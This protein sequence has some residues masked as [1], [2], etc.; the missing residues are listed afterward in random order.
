M[1]NQDVVLGKNSVE[2]VGIVKE[3]KL[4]EITYTK[5]GQEFEAISGSLV[6]ACGEFKTVE[7]RLMVNKL[8]KKGTVNKTYEKLQGFI[9]GDYLTMVD[10][11]E[12]ATRVKIRGNGD[13]TPKLEENRFAN[14]ERTEVI[15]APSVSL[16][17]GNITIDNTIPEEDFKAMVDVDVYIGSIEEEI[18]NNDEETGRV[19]MQTYL[20]LY[21]KEGLDIMPLK[22]VAGV[23][24]ATETEDECDVAQAVRDYISEGD[25]VNMWIDIN[26][27]RIVKKVAKGG[28]IGR[29]K[30]EDS[31]TYINEFVMIG[32]EP[33]DDVEKQFDE[34][35]I[36]KALQERKIRL[37][38]VLTDAITRDEVNATVNRGRGI[39]A[40]PNGRR[41]VNTNATNH[42]SATTNGTTRRGSFGF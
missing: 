36:R 18:N 38:S 31:T 1:E 11:I 35:F 27:E 6:I 23:L 33:I 25:T 34:D 20:P 7:I 3:Q 9:Q 32:G 2:I 41:P 8:T 21:A 30:I 14:K 10:N 17:F 39:S 24:P 12:E 4:K 15:T 13:F 42:D 5:D 26:H 29:A 22:V 19:I 16:G 40:R 28:G 37:D